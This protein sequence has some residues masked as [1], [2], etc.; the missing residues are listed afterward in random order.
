MHTKKLI[1][2]HSGDPIKVILQPATMDDMNFWRKVSNQDREFSKVKSKITIGEHAGWFK[3]KLNFDSLYIIRD[4]HYKFGTLR[5]SN[6]RQPEVHISILPIWQ[7]KGLATQAMYLIFEKFP[8]LKAEVLF[9]NERSFNFFLSV[10]FV[11]K[12]IVL[13]R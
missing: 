7:N 1:A 3:E 4:K 11:P 5:V 9:G 8:H 13:E 10:G 6:F 2:M 12:T